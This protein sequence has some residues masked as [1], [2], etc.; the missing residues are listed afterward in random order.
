MLAIVPL[1]LYD[2]SG[3]TMKASAGCPGYPFTCRWDAGVVG[4]GYVTRKGAEAM[5]CKPGEKFTHPRTK[6]IKA[7]DREFFE[8]AIVGEVQT[9]DDYLTGS[10]YGYQVLD[11]DGDHVDSCW[12][13]YVSHDE[14]DPDGDGGIGFVRQQAREAAEASKPI[15]YTPSKCNVR[16]EEARP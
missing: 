5:G 2:H 3:I 6:E 13:F 14:K 12:G 8:A 10:C 16:C 1:W 15:G 4:W 7:Y 9:Y 11:E